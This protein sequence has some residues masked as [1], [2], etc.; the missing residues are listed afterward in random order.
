[1]SLPVHDWYCPFAH[2]WHVLPVDVW[3]LPIG[4]S[5]HDEEPATAYLP[6]VQFVHCAALKTLE[7]LPLAQLVQPYGGKDCLS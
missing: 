3:Y 2:E 7:N 4:Q 1:M 5:E 6:L